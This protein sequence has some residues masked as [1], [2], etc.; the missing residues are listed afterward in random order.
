MSIVAAVLAGG[1]SRRMGTDKALIR[2]DPAGPTLLESVL[3]RIAA[4]A[5][6]RFII[7]TDRPEYAA[8]GVPVEPDRYPGAAALGGIATALE[9]SAGAPCLVVP[10]DLPFLNLSLL[11]HLAT[12]AAGADVVVPVVRGESR[13][14]GGFI[15]QTLHAVYG[16]ACLP[17]IRSQLARGER[18]IVRF[19]D[20]IRVAAVEEEVVR[21]F[22]PELWTFF[23]VNT[24]EA[25]AR[26]RAHQRDLMA[27][28]GAP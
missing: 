3:D 7:A 6:R 24:P 19:F 5:D 23:N 28:C 8:F 17:P 16:P 11:S 13:Q 1:M 26:A 22:D 25:L 2:L 9:V 14:Q 12:R 15:Y 20:Q 10:C 4:V 21:G 27:D 18:Q